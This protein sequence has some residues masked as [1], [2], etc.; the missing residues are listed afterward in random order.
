MSTFP[1]RAPPSSASFYFERSGSRRYGCVR[2]R[3][4]TG[5]TI[6]ARFR[7]E[8]VI[9]DV[10]IPMARAAE[11]CEFLLREIGISPVW[12]CPFK[13]SDRTYDLCP[14][15]PNQ[16]YVNFGFWD[17]VPSTLEN[18]Y[19]NRL[20]ER[21]IAELGGVKGLYS[22]SYY[23]RDTFWSIYD[24]LR[25]GQLKQTYDAAAVF[26]DLYAKCVERQ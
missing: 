18:G 8:S 12:V 10:D 1:W 13:N 25:Y 21:K 26:P 16:V 14:L 3:T 19:Y 4:R 20:I 22:A 5:L 15:P 17:M 7:S 24:K 6:C 9:Q 23:D 2:S 11:F